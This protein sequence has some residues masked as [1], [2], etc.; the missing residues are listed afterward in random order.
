[1]GAYNALDDLLPGAAW[2]PDATPG[3]PW[4]DPADPAGAPE[5]PRRPRLQPVPD[6]PPAR[7][8]LDDLLPGPSAPIGRRRGAG[9][10]LRGAARHLG[11]W[12]PLDDL[13]PAPP[14]ADGGAA[15]EPAPRKT[16]VS[17]RLPADLVEEARDA[18]AHLAG[19]V[20]RSSLTALAERA[21]RAELARLASVHNRGRRFP[22]RAP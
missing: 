11:V 1:M 2:G 4:P 12:N 17:F 10:R 5:A 3:D 13:G 6:R 7:N 14:A 18:A 21:I 19:T 8:A 22:P 16:R 15:R 9:P 20:D